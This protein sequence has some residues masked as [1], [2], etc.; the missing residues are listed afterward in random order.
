MSGRVTHPD[1]AKIRLYAAIGQRIRE[2]A[3]ENDVSIAELAR[4]IG[5]T[6]STLNHCVEGS[7]IPVHMLVAVAEHFDVSLDNLVPC[8]TEADG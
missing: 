7:S 1:G 3:E 4:A 6:P 5:T 2:L 8:L